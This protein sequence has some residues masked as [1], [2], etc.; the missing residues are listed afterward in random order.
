MSPI[1]GNPAFTP[2]GPLNEM[3][4]SVEE[5]PRSPTGDGTTGT[6]VIKPRPQTPSAPEGKEAEPA[7]P[8][9]MDAAPDVKHKTIDALVMSQNRISRNRWAIDT[10]FNRIRAGTPFSRLDKIPNQSIWIAKLPNGMNKES[11]A[12]VPNKADDLCNKIEDTLMSDP[13]KPLASPPI[14]EESAKRA[15]EMLTKALKLALGPTGINDI[16]NHRWSIRNA[17]PGASS[18]LHYIS[19]PTL[20]GYQPMQKLAHPLAED[21]NN[22]LVAMT[23]D[24]PQTT[25]DPILRYVRGNQ[26][27]ESA[28][29]AEKVWLPGIR[30]ERLKR[31]AVRVFPPTARV[32]DAKAVILL[33][34]MTVQEAMSEWPETVGKMASADLLQLASWRPPMAEQIVPY[35]FKGGSDGASGPTVEEVGSF[36]PLLQ[37]RMFSYRLYV[38][39]SP[40]YPEGYYCDTANM[41]SGTVL[42]EGTLEYTVT[43]PV[44]GKAKRCRD[45]PITQY[46]PQPDVQG[47]DPMGWPVIGRFA[48]SSEAEAT[49]YAAFMDF[50]DNM[51][52]PHVYL[53]GTASVDEEDWFDRTKP[54]ML[55]P[56]DQKPEYEQFPQIPPILQLI[57]N[58]DTKMDTISGLTATAQGLDSPNSA[59]GVAKNLTIR[60]AQV[61]MSGF[62]Q[63]LH[64]AM[65]RGWRIMG[66]IMQ[67]DYSTP[68]LMQFTGDEDSD[69]PIWWTGEDLA[70]VDRIGIQPG[71]GTMMT[72]E[73]KAQ[74]LAYYQQ[75]LWLQP[76]AA[77]DIALPAM[78]MDLGIPKNPFESAIE[79]SIALFLQGPPEGWVEQKQM[80]MQQM[81]AYQQMVAPLQMQAQQGVQVQVPPAPQSKLSTPF[82]VRPN[83]DEPQVAQVYFKRLSKLFVD[84]EFSA[85]PPEW[86]Q[87]AIEAYT[88]A[89]A[90]MQAIQMAGQ[91]PQPA[92]TQKAG[93][94]PQ[95]PPKAPGE[96]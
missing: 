9:L 59:S 64:G 61:S 55:G 3:L 69:D 53:R 11:S 66:Q 15:A 36:S 5:V 63:E 28:E 73:S 40:E 8:T 6:G 33:R 45:I 81:Q 83:D 65:C 79:R 96:M 42:G 48:G 95:G 90:V 88:R 23:P 92:Q 16:A 38:A 41:N 68:Q 52:H 62:Q 43:L 19:D 87:T 72:P 32:E 35:A 58:L 24:G 34:H 89:K 21:P 27:V 31:E 7:Q 50:C 54:I 37:R 85:Q 39:A 44:H 70:G 93:S 2:M 13:A 76:E 56:S 20:S 26:F 4:A 17:L 80:E 84:P 86:Q 51:L 14:N 74:V 57:E 49:L 29:D 78:R 10:H 25:S 67:A 91:Q 30:V 71:T 12:S 22:P 60:Q 75:N 77:S 94:Q 1:I 18:F 46:T 47:G 82:P